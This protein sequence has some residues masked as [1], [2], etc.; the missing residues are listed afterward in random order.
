MSEQEEEDTRN[1]H[2]CQ[3]DFPPCAGANYSICIVHGRAQLLPAPRPFI[4]IKETPAQ[5]PSQ[6]LY[7]QMQIYCE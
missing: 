4:K 5:T 3:P 1:P 2:V 6:T 7:A